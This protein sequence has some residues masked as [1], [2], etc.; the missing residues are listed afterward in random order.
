MIHLVLRCDRLTYFT[1]HKVVYKATETKGKGIYIYHL[2]K[3]LRFQN[4]KI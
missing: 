1:N 2:S 3:I 4:P